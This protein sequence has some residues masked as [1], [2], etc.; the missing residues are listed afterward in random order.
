[1]DTTSSLNLSKEAKT[2]VEDVVDGEYIAISVNNS[3]MKLDK[4]YYEMIGES[5]LIYAATALH[6]RQRWDRFEAWCDHHADWSEP[7]KLR[8]RELW[9]QQYR[10]LPVNQGEDLEPHT[11][12][13]S[14]S[15]IDRCR[16]ISGGRFL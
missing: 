2:R 13:P 16:S 8:V 5:H 14:V 4:Y 1:M 15:S 6:P 3:W 10:D 11:K 9:R 12:V 7:A